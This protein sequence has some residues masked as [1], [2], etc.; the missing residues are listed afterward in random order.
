MQLLSIKKTKTFLTK[1][2]LNF[3]GFGL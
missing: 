2:I 3:K 1:D